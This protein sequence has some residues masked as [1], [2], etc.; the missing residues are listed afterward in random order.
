MDSTTTNVLY[1]IM[2]ELFFFYLQM[3]KRTNWND[4][5]KVSML[6]NGK[7][8]DCFIL[9]D[10]EFR[11]IV[12][13]HSN[14]KG[15]SKVRTLQVGNPKRSLLELNVNIQY[16]H[17]YSEVET[18][19]VKYWIITPNNSWHF[20]TIRDD[21]RDTLSNWCSE[22]NS[23]QVIAKE[24]SSTYIKPFN[25][26]LITLKQALQHF[27]S[28][29]QMPPIPSNINEDSLLNDIYQHLSGYPNT[30]VRW[31]IDY[32]CMVS[33]KYTICIERNNISKSIKREDITSP[34]EK[35]KFNP[36]LY[37]CDIYKL[38][39]MQDTVSSIDPSNNELKLLLHEVIKNGYLIDL[40]ERQQENEDSIKQAIN[41]DE[42]DVNKLI[43]NDEILTILNEVKIL[44]RDD[45]HKQ[46]GYP[47][48]LHQICAILLYCGKPC[49]VQFSKDQIQFQHY[50]WSFLDRSLQ[51]AISILNSHE[52]RE[53]ESIDLYCGLATVRLENIKEIKQGFFISHVSTSDDIQVAQIYRSDRGCAIH[54]CDVSWI[55]PFEHEREI[56]FSRSNSA[57]FLDEKNKE[58][59]TWNARIENENENTQMILLTWTVYDEFIQQTVRISKMWNHAIDLNLIYVISLL[60]KDEDATVVHL[61]LFEEWR[62]KPNNERKY[63]E[64]KKKFMENRCC[65]HRINLFSIYYCEEKGFQE[66]TPIE[67]AT[68]ATVLK[69]LPFQLT[70]NEI[71]IFLKHVICCYFIQ[72]YNLKT[73]KHCNSLFVD[74]SHQNKKTKSGLI[75][76]INHFVKLFLPDKKTF[77]KI[78]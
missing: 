18:N 75:F 39:K 42:Q 48:Q 19:Y 66:Y 25:P 60:Q 78:I 14:Q 47:L 41:Y 2:F 61:S 49:N 22:F 5:F 45:I 62:K 51:G 11:R 6:S 52:R 76:F 37:E 63:E 27:K 50:K 57:Q 53:E 73:Q 77:K 64:K 40:I 67:F 30:Q 1:L 8:K 56:L 17:D 23:F 44:Y 59:T 38:K 15:K 10:Y 36:L 26:Y 32:K 68:I 74:F 24:N 55:S 12:L 13:L 71:K 72:R 43:L 29:L 3:D 35:H 58:K 54:S 16:R 21:N 4:P 7:W 34:K 65:N 70:I 33:H 46:M 69:G 9:F 31:K 20:R 28:Q